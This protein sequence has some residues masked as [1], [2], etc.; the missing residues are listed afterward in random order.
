MKSL[1]PS[2]LQP[3]LLSDNER[4]YNTGSI[5]W[6]Q[7]GSNPQPLSTLI[8]T[9]NPDSLSNAYVTWQEHI[10]TCTVQMSTHNTAQL[11]DQFG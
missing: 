10:V 4:T 6:L 1:A 7:L 5:K 3:Y 11:F 8:S 9:Q 2:Y